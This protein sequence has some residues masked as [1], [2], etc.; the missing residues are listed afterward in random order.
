MKYLV[1]FLFMALIWADC[2]AF[3]E[4]K[5]AEVADFFQLV[6]QYKNAETKAQYTAFK[7]YLEEHKLPVEILDDSLQHSGGSLHMEVFGEFGVVCELGGY[8]IPSGFVVFIDILK[9]TIVLMDSEFPSGNLSVNTIKDPGATPQ[10]LFVVKFRTLT[11]I[12][13]SS[14]SEKVYTIDGHHLQLSLQKPCYECLSI[15]DPVDEPETF[16]HQQRNIF[17]VSNKQYV[18]RSSGTVE[19]GDSDSVVLTPPE[20]YYIWDTRSRQFAQVEGRSTYGHN[21]LSTIYGDFTS[22]R[23]DEWFKMTP[24]Y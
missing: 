2:S 23:I 5:G 18:I 19:I 22:F 13:Y 6:K 7:A 8:K 1:R 14:F 3:S 21:R 17:T 11:G 16:E 4:E 24:C 15:W 20:E 10:V 9:N 12:G